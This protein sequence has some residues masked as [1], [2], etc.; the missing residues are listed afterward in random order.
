MRALTIEN[1]LI[2][3]KFFERIENYYEQQ[4]RRKKKE[5]QIDKI[6]RKKSV[7]Q[8]I[9]EN[10]LQRERVLCM[11]MCGCVVLILVWCILSRL[12]STITYA[13]YFF[14]YLLDASVFKLQHSNTDAAFFSMHSIQMIHCALSISHKLSLFIHLLPFFFA[15]SV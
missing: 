2:P 4:K 15:H 9:L 8:S 1:R 14:F 12:D 7:V 5:N 10:E 11:C 6:W 3:Y 13:C